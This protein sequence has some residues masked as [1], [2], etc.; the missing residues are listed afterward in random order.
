MAKKAVLVLNCVGP[1]SNQPFFVSEQTVLSFLA[2]ADILYSRGPEGQKTD[3]LLDSVGSL[4]IDSTKVSQ[5]SVRL[6]VTLFLEN[7]LIGS[8]YPTLLLF[9]VKKKMFDE[10]ER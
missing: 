2:K 5:N 4:L 1:V 9:N 3:D 7:V 10:P 6:F 8:P